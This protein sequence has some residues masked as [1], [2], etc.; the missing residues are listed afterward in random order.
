MGEAKRSTE[1]RNDG[2]T[3]FNPSYSTRLN[4]MDRSFIFLTKSKFKYRKKRKLSEIII[5]IAM[6]GLV[7]QKYADSEVMHILIFLAHVAW[8]R[9]TKSVD[10]CQKD[11]YI[12]FLSQF[13]LPK[14]KICK[15]LVSDDWEMTINRMIDYK[16][17]HFPDDRRIITVCEYTARKTLRVEWQEGT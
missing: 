10:Y 13:H 16:R 14:S 17:E 7:S 5:E 12:V 1:L 2:F 3:S 8:N 4:N 15:E 6:Q 9:D 11:Q